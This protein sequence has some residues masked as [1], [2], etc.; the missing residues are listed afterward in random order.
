MSLV[1]ILGRNNGYPCV[2][3]LSDMDS[4]QMTSAP[5]PK[6]M[7]RVYPNVNNGY[8]SVFSLPERKSVKLKSSPYSS[9]MM[10]CLGSSVNQGYPVVIQLSD[11]K[12]DVLSKL[13]FAE[14]RISAMYYNENYISS[15]FCNEQKM[16]GISYS[17]G[18]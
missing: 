15:A 4:I 16:F 3:E 7:L 17:S 1:I 18:S 12:K 11:V 8:P 2:A 6:W 5:Y 10:R 14:M 13:R 9:A